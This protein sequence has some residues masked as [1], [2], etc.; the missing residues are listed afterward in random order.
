MCTCCTTAVSTQ[1]RL[2]RTAFQTIGFTTTVES[3]L[4]VSAVVGGTSAR[5]AVL[6]TPGGQSSDR[7]RP[8]AEAKHLHAKEPEM[9]TMGLVVGGMDCRRCVREVT[10]R[11]RN[12]PALRP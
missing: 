1:L 2:L 4:V 6:A 5:K 11:L 3:R 12:V 7:V 8:H 9:R 10:A